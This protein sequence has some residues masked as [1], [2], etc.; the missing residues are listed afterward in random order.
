MDPCQIAGHDIIGQG[1][2]GA[3][4]FSKYEPKEKPAENAVVKKLL[5]TAQDLQKP[6]RRQRCYIVTAQE[7]CIIQGC[8]RG[9]YGDDVRFPLLKTPR[10]K[11]SRF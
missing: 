5:S 7:H 3:V 11:D 2:F 8:L 6:L 4:F 10:F 1:T 9:T